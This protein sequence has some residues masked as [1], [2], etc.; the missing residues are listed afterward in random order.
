MG[1]WSQYLWRW[2][3]RDSNLNWTETHFGVR[4]LNKI[5]SEGF[6][7]RLWLASAG[8]PLILG[9]TRPILITSSGLCQF[10]VP[11]PPVIILIIHWPSSLSRETMSL[12][13][14]WNVWIEDQTR[15][16][17]RFHFSIVVITKDFT[18]QALSKFS[19]NLYNQLFDKV[20][21]R[22]DTVPATK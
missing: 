11:S 8:I 16:Y 2:N 10:S 1:Q 13:S 17:N 6:K 4:R 18:N 21:L 5:P 12:I 9:P 19:S 3:V 7:F 15:S 22:K 14:S 20:Y